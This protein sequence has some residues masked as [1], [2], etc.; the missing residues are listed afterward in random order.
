MVSYYN[1]P[2]AMYQKNHSGPNLPSPYSASQSAAWYSSNYHQPPSGQFLGDSDAPPQYYP[3]HMFHQSSPDWTGHENYA[4]PPQ[5]N[6]LIH[7]ST[8]NGGGPGFLQSN[9]NHH[10]NVN[11]SNEHI[12]D[13]LHSLPSPPIT[14]SGS[15]MSSP[16]APNG[17]SSPQNN[18]NRPTPVKSPYEWMKKPSY[19]SQPNPGK[20]RTKD[21]YRVVYTDHQRLELEKEFHF[22]R[23][24]TIRRKSELAQSLA[25]SERQ[26]KI[27]FQNRRAKDRK[28]KKKMDAGGNMVSSN[29]QTIISQSHNNNNHSSALANLSNMLDV[30]PKI[31]P[32]LE[33]L[34]HFHHMNAMGMGIG[35]MGLHAH[36]A[37]H[38]HHLPP[39][40]P[41]TSMHQSPNPQ[42]QPSTPSSGLMLN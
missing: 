29:G 30:K 34:Q 24:I 4:P 38:S 39:P 22:T 26:V 36:H 18:S 3:H 35:Q 9:Q 14:V 10:A 41:P 20:T 23:Y 2:F 7:G 15:D 17:P 5:T 28:Q 31:E 25:L 12:N 37:M 16:G 11:N 6:P 42:Q 27:W 21:K 19:Q 1:H 33:H 8:G 13:G 32:S 40:M